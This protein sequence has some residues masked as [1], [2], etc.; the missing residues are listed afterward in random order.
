MEDIIKYLSESG[1][2]VKAGKIHQDDVNLA[3]EVLAAQDLV[4]KG[5]DWHDEYDSTREFS[6]TDKDNNIVDAILVALWNTADAER[7]LGFVLNHNSSKDAET[8]SMG[9]FIN[10]TDYPSK[11]EVKQDYDSASK[12]LEKIQDNVGSIDEAYKALK[13]LG[14]EHYK[15]A[16]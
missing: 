6:F 7:S 5:Y 16:Y 12:V 3:I 10:G 9:K 11:D 1:V 4:S 15:D 8:L 14:W 13:S 2:R